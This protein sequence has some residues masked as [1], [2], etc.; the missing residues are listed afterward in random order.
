[1]CYEENK[2]WFLDHVYK[3]CAAGKL[4]EFLNILRIVNSDLVM[5]SY[6]SEF[7]TQTLSY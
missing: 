3:S 4:I 2:Q 5:L 6:K 1:M 7:L